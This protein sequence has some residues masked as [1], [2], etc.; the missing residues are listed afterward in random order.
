MPS[1][2]NPIFTWSLD[3]REREICQRHH[4]KLFN[5]FQKFK[6]IIDMVL[7]K[8][9]IYQ[10]RHDIISQSLRKGFVVS[11]KCG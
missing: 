8:L 5:I 10:C 6:I 9:C 1:L 7:T 2:P 3:T 11:A 4:I